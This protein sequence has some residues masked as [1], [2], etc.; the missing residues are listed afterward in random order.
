MTHIR[1]RL[2]AAAAVLTLGA[3]LAGGI[4]SAYAGKPAHHL[5]RH[6]S[7]HLIRAGYLTVGSDT[8][9]PPMESVNPGTGKYVGADVDLAAALAHA[10]GLKGAQIVNNTFDTIIPALQRHKFDVIMS[11]MN[12][13]PQRAQVIS[14]VDYMRA[15]EGI[16]VHTSSTIHANNYSGFCGHSIAVER[17]TTELDGLNIAAKHCKINIKTYTLDT[18]AFE[19]FVSGHAEAYTGD[20]PVAAY[21][22]KQHRSTMRL[23][24]KPI[25]AGEDYGIGL[26]K[27]NHALKTALQRALHKIMKNG[28]YRQ[29]LRTWGVGGAGF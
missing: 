29:I 1:P 20:L 4:G 18:D 13:T 22:V 8:T 5:S 24:G 21:Y 19:A 23:A 17:G 11:S 27:G 14:F 16:V 7:L 15:S 10:M 3:L 28:L 25:S 9:Y 2:R 26:L 12:D 6:A